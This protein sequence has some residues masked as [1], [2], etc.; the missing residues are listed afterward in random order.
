MDDGL[1]FSVCWESGKYKVFLVRFA[2]SCFS[3]SVHRMCLQAVVVRVGF[4]VLVEVEVEVEVRTMTMMKKIGL[5]LVDRR[6]TNA[7][8]LSVAE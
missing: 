7:G 8:C 6:Q 4:V 5:N 1:R 2:G 3:T